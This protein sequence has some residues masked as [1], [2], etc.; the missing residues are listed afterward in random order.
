MVQRTLQ[1]HRTRSRLN[2]S[3]ELNW[4]LHLC[5]DIEIL[6]TKLYKNSK[7]LIVF[8]LM[9]TLDCVSTIRTL[10]FNSDICNNSHLCT[11]RRLHQHLV[12]IYYYISF[13]VEAAQ[14]TGLEKNQLI[15]TTRCSWWNYNNEEIQVILHDVDRLNYHFFI[16]LMNRAFNQC[17][18]IR[19]NGS[20]DLYKQNIKKYLT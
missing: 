7:T 15:Y 10:F 17:L 1:Y 9:V 20:I 13:A 8:Y 14:N 2:G 12:V 4:W 18:I 3:R 6:E 19:I 5:Q 11:P 16:R